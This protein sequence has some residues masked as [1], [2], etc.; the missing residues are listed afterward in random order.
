MGGGLDHRGREHRLGGRPGAGH[1]AAR[2]PGPRDRR[3]DAHGPA[4]RR[5]LRVLQRQKRRT[6]PSSGRWRRAPTGPRRTSSGCVDGGAPELV[7]AIGSQPLLDPTGRWMVSDVPS[8]TG[9]TV[10]PVALLDVIDGGRTEIAYGVP[11]QSCEVVG[12]LDPGELLAYCL[13]A[14]YAVRRHRSTRP[15]CT[16]R[17]TGSTSPRRG[18]PPRSCP[19]PRTGDPRPW[20]WQGGWAGPGTLAVAGTL[21]GVRRPR[22]LRGRT[23]T[24]GPARPCDRR[25]WIPAD[26]LHVPVGRSRCSSS[27]SRAAAARRRPSSSAPST[28]P[29]ARRRCWRRC[30]RRPR[31]CPSGG[32]ASVLGA[33]R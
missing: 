16:L 25:T 29:R 32:A 4:T 30:R 1:R 20:T 6:A 18:P 7:G 2:R 10:D 31:R 14:G 27:R 24:S 8:D 5:R 33:G 26:D 19:D 23:C 21:G 12:W 9:D 3:A 17:T 13:D 28:P 22:R 11:G 15:P